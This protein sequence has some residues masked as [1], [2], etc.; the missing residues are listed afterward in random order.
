[1]V[2]KPGEGHR[3][4]CGGEGVGTEQQ[5]GLEVTEVSFELEV[6]RLDSLKQ[7]LCLSQ[8]T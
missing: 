8:Y 1:M 2:G 6:N 7:L 4:G 5:N 3:Q